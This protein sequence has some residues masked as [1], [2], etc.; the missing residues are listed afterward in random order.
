MLNAN[1]QEREQPNAVVT[2]ARAAR[3][4]NQEPKMRAALRLHDYLVS[5]HWN[6]R[7]L[8]GP[9][10]GIR[11]NY[12][13]GRFIK[14]YLP[15]VHWRDSYCYLQAQGYWILDNWQLYSITRDGRYRDFA[16]R[17]SEFVLSQQLQEGSWLYPNPEWHGRIATA[18]GTWG[19]L[20]L[21]ESYRQ[22]GDP[23]VLE[24]ILKWYRFVVEEIGF[25]VFGQELAVNYFHANKGSRVPNNSTILL[26]FLAEL[27]DAT[28]NVSYRERCAGLLRFLSAVQKPT[29]EFP[30]TVSG[31]GGGK[32]W[33][34]FQCFQYNAFQC[35]DLM[36]YFDLTGDETVLPLIRKLLHFLRGGVA[37]D[38]HSCFDCG[39]SHRT[40]AY[41]TAVLAQALVRASG[42]E[43]PS[44]DTL[45]N[46]AYNYLLALQ[47]P[48]GGF[49][50]S[51]GDY[52]FFRDRRSYPRNLAMI[53]Y[54]LLP[55]ARVQAHHPV[56]L[57][58]QQS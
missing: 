51:R 11:L 38:G 48:D 31:I 6:G 19:C 46:R 16:V 37:E 7:A 28:A 27:A 57:S 15:T 40:V 44:Y 21:L 18:E 1:T 56:P 52:Y 4:F 13:I 17:C 8:I 5:S 20:G 53:L 32:I 12:R 42:F 23:R 35:L 39:N 25:Q 34:H 49:H 54:H 24:G 30:Y 45:A 29:G 14:S 3:T 10:Q 58:L 50:F 47:R 41:H 2:S 36:R 22:T 55:V 33:P 26:R 43:I 9:D